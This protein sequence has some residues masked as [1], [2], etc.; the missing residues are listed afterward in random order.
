MASKMW[1]CPCCE[2]TNWEDKKSCRHC[3]LWRRPRKGK[4][5]YND[6]S[7]GGLDH[8]MKDL[9]REAKELKD[10][11]AKSNIARLAAERDARHAKAAEVPG[12]AKLTSTQPLA[13]R[14]PRPSA[15]LAH[16][17][18]PPPP[19]PPAKMEVP[20]TAAGARS[21]HKE[22]KARLDSLIATRVQCVSLGTAPEFLEH[23][24]QEIADAR[25]EIH[26]AKPCWQ[27]L[28]VAQR[29]VEDTKSRIEK[30]RNSVSL[31][32]QQIRD[33]EYLLQEDTLEYNTLLHEIAT[34]GAATGGAEEAENLILELCAKLPVEDRVRAIGAVAALAAR[35][36]PSPPQHVPES[37]SDEDMLEE[38]RDGT[39]T[40]VQPSANNVNVDRELSP[41]GQKRLDE[42]EG[43]RIARRDRRGRSRSP[44][45]A[46]PPLAEV[47]PLP[48]HAAGGIAVPN[49]LEVPERFALTPDALDPSQPAA[50]EHAEAFA[51]CNVG[52]AR[53]SRA[54]RP[55]PYPLTL[56]LDPSQADS[57]K[58]TGEVTG[59]ACG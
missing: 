14:R 32:K 54:P 25:G 55:D 16:L 37:D 3:T 2:T 40:P 19:P 58:H 4:S 13:K 22:L 27:R 35:A 23:I 10:K 21:S 30:Y 1:V 33:A 59:Q 38:E 28:G 11:L 36:T 9:E 18:P 57:Q 43:W 42:L 39:A 20:G 41:D 6:N 8:R 52:P 50:E 47:P 56:D 51:A 29:K 24:N 15:G 12:S 26:D 17:P 44:S 45:R 7:Q 49:S 34:H 31:L 5:P 48:G 46:A 53:R